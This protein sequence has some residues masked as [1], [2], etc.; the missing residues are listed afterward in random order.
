MNVLKLRAA[1]TALFL[2]LAVVAGTSAITTTSAVAG[3]R[4]AVGKPLQEAQSLAAAGNYSAAMAQVNKAEA[5][6]GLT[7]EESRIVSQ[8]RSYISSKS[9]ATGGK[10]KFSADYRAATWSAGTSVGA[11]R[12]GSAASH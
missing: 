9:S 10:G 12:G 1:V 8:M 11:G 4:P 7:P 6:G 3:V 2:G 5:V